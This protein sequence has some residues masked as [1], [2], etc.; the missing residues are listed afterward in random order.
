[1]TSSRMIFAMAFDRVLPDKLAK[2]NEKWHS[3][4]NA[5]IFVSL[6]SLIGCAAEANLFGTDSPLYLGEFIRYVINPGGAIVATDLWDTIFFLIVCIAAFYFPIRK[7][8]IFERSPF[9]ASKTITQTIAGLA[10][11]GNLI[12]FWIFAT[13]SHGWNLFGITGLASAMP[14]LFS[15]FLTLLGLGIYLYYSNKAKATGVELTTIFT[16]IP[17]D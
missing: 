5:I 13:D 3:P 10:I 1:L 9:R 6:V 4:V 2:V 7:P 14:F 17:P 11:I 12:A 15:I 16:E 8:E